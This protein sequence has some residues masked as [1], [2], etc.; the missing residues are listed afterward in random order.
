MQKEFNT[1]VIAGALCNL[2]VN[3][4]LIPKYGAAGACIGTILSEY[5]VTGIQWHFVR[6]QIRLEGVGM[7]LVRSLAAGTVM[8]AV[9][10]GSEKLMP[11]SIA[12]TIAQIAMGGVVYILLLFIMQDVFAKWLIGTLRTAVRQRFGKG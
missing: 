2:T 10:M 4:L 1:S 12:S 8:L 11:V 9:L 5:L 3:C 6:K 7:S